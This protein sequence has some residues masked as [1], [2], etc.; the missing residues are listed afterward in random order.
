MMC[1]IWAST[2][3]AFLLN[4]G[5]GPSRLICTVWNL[6]NKGKKEK[7]M[8]EQFN[9]EIKNTFYFFSRNRRNENFCDH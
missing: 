7:E 9:F 4:N 5:L 8:G 2:Y 6:K 1:C 3:W